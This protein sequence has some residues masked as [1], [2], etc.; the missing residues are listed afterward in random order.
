MK[1]MLLIYDREQT[2]STRSE[3]ES[4]EDMNKWMAFDERARKETTILDGQAL[5]PTM[6]ATTVR[7][8][9]TRTV[10]TD[11][12]FAETKEQLGGYYVIDAKDLDQAMAM[13]GMMP[14]LA[15][16]GSVEI[17]PVMEIPGQ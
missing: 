10:S 8:N 3:K 11:G 4:Q 16:G 9:G 2:A 13:A 5:Q 14:H 15:H 6:T 17:R 7:A 1:Y 12:P